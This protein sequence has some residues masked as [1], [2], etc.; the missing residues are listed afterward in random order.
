MRSQTE[1]VDGRH[2]P[3]GHC[4]ANF[5]EVPRDIASRPERLPVA[6]SVLCRGVGRGSLL[7]IGHAGPNDRADL[8][9]VGGFHRRPRHVGPLQ[10][11]RELGGGEC[12]GCR[13]LG[14]GLVSR[15]KPVGIGPRQARRNRPPRPDRLLPRHRAAA[16]P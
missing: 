2:S 13:D 16:R 3:T 6:G 7:H 8:R 10:R 4:I 5:Q 15:G 14:A 9:T 11:T 1:G 12:N